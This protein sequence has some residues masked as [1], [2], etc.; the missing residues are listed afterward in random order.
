MRKFKINLKPLAGI[1]RKITLFPSIDLLLEAL[2]LSEIIEFQTG[3]NNIS[4]LE[5]IKL[6][7]KVFTAMLGFF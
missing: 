3:G 2:D 7:R 6:T 4:G 1:D 5:K